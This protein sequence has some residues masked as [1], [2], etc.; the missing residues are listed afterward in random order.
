MA[1]MLS[2]EE[3]RRSAFIIAGFFGLLAYLFISR[4]LGEGILGCPFRWA[5]GYSCFGCGMTRSTMAF[6]HGELAHAVQFHPFGPI[7]VVGWAVAA[8][9]QGAQLIRGEALNYAAVRVWRRHD[10]LIWWVGAAFLATFGAI[11]LGLELAGIL[12]PV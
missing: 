5:S 11:R 4:Q 9:H 2:K 6:V 1:P 8:F 7:F 3:R 12:T 10:K